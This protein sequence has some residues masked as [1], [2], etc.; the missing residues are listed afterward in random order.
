MVMFS[1]PE[2]SY[3]TSLGDSRWMDMNIF[4]HLVGC[5][6]NQLDSIRVDAMVVTKLVM[7]I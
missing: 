1:L 3:P 7:P 4:E 5:V 2:A 6:S